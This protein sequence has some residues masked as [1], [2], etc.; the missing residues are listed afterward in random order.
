MAVRPAVAQASSAQ[1]GWR[2]AVHAL[3]R[4]WK[5]AHMLYRVLLLIR[6]SL[7]L[8][9]VCSLV[10]LFNDQA[11]DVLRVLGEDGGWPICGSS[12]RRAQRRR[13]LVVGAG[14]VLFPLS[15]PG[16][17]AACFRP[18]GVSAARLGR[19]G[20]GPYRA[21]GNPGLL[22]LR[23]M[24]HRPGRAAATARA[25]AALLAAGFV[26][27]TVHRRVWFARWAGGP[28][29]AN[30]LCANSTGKLGCRSS[31]WRRSGSAS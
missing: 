20:A 29:P 30:L 2:V 17:R 25:R 10:L 4:C 26:Y 5:Q 28:R 1:S 19:V 27:V 22:Q 23:R 16:V 12:R 7:L 11:Q 24:D 31:W 21:R 8:G 3:A 9:L 15:Q 6:F 13:R 18:Q 14:D